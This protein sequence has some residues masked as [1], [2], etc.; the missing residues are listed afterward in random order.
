MTKNSNGHGAIVAVVE[1]DDS[2]VF[3][4]A[5]VW[6]ECDPSGGIVLGAY[7]RAFPANTASGSEPEPDD[8]LNQVGGGTDHWGAMTSHPTVKFK[9]RFRVDFLDEEDPMNPPITVY[10]VSDE[11]MPPTRHFSTSQTRRR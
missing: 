7:A 11:V 1:P 8:Q 3:D 4:Q 2:P 9:V 10:A 5:Q 6:V